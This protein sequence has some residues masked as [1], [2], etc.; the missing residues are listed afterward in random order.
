MLEMKAVVMTAAGPPEMLQ[1][2]TLPRPHIQQPRDLLVRL[3]AAGVNPIDTKL[4]QR[5]TYYP[6]SLPTILGLDGAGIVEAVGP[7]VRH[8]SVGDEVYFCNGGLGNQPGTYAEYTLVDERFVTLKPRSLSF[9]EAAAVPLVLI[10]TWEALYDRLQLEMGQRILIH[11][12]AGGVGHMAIQLAKLRNIEVFT[13][14]SSEEKA[15]FAGLMGAD[16]CIYYPRIDFV[17]AVLN[18]TGKRGVDAAFDTVG[19]P[20]LSKTFSAVRLYGEVV[21]LHS[22]TPETDWRTARNQNLRISYELMLT[23]LLN[24]LTEAQHQQAKILK[25]GTRCFDAG[26][27]KIHVGQTY[28][29]EQAAEAHRQLEAGGILGKVVLEMA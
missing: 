18:L 20:V 13:T 14:I 4:R 17:E 29:L 2:Q 3:R 7:D 10:T 9:I 6:D 1:V 23:P 25:Q 15:R 21:T 22:A 19:E 12:G 27:L 5:G 28:S 8:F 11:A 24:S 26:K 16:H